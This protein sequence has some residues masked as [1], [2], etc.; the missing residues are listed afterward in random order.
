M[1]P[2]R[3]QTLAASQTNPLLVHASGRAKVPSR[4]PPANKKRSVLI[5]SH[6]G[7]AKGARNKGFADGDKSDKMATTWR[8]V[9]EDCSGRRQT[10]RIMGLPEESRW[11][12]Q[13]DVGLGAG[14]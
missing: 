13:V 9:S 2:A 14:G 1:C 12:S 8:S 4:T 10:K 3:F 11:P 5:P 6:C 7:R